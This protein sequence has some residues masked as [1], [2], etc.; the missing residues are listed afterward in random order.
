VLIKKPINGQ[1][2]EKIFT[3][4]VRDLDEN[5]SLERIVGAKSLERIV[6]AL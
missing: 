2:Q 6:G 1:G 4:K 3:G 5:I